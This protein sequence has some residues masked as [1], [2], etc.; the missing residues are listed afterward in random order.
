MAGAGLSLLGIK[1]KINKLLSIAF[2]Y[3]FFVFSIR[4]MYFILGIPLGTH[5]FILMTVFTLLLRGIAKTNLLTS[6]IATLMSTLLIFWGE[7]VFLFPAVMILKIDPIVFSSARLGYTL[8]GIVL[9]DILLIIAFIIG[10]CLNKPLIN[11]SGDKSD[12]GDKH[13]ATK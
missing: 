4:N 6:I 7:G 3:G 5:V 10:Y 11:L 9:S 12:I 2:I 1:L 13:E 8:L